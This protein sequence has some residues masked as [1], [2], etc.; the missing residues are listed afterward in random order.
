[1]QSARQL[2]DTLTSI[3]INPLL[4]LIFALGLLVFIWGIVEFLLSYNLKDFSDHKENG[5]KHM[6]WGIIGMFI[7]ASAYTMVHLIE[8][9]FPT[10]LTRPFN[11]GNKE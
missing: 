7:M 4:L 8:N 1:M 6:L 2:V 9:T 3:I 5:K 11:D 10:P